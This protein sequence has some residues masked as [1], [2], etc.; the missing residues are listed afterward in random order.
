VAKITED[1]IE[2]YTIEELE[3]LGYQFLH[4]PDISPD[5]GSPERQ[6]YGEVVLAGRHRSAIEKLD[7]DY[8]TQR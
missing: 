2:L 6:T 1:E 4:G 5:G 3:S 7:A 8:F